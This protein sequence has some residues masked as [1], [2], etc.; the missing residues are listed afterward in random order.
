MVSLV[1]VAAAAAGPNDLLLLLS[2]L[3]AEGEQVEWRA[4]LQP[5]KWLC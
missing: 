5:L 1:D 2:A 3:V 4:G